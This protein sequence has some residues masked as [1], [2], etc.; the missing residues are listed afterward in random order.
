MSVFCGACLAAAQCARSAQG[1]APA[2]LSWPGVA[3]LGGMGRPRPSVHPCL[4][5]VQAGRLPVSGAAFSVTGVC[6][7]FPSNLCVVGESCGM[8]RVAV[9]DAG[10]L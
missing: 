9:T 7:C 4:G 2:L 8:A 10:E 6:S 1:A 3:W 5:L